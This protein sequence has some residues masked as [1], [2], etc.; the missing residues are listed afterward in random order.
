[1]TDLAGP[2]VRVLL[3]YAGAGLMTKAGIS[4]DIT[5]PDVMTLAEFAIGGLL[6]V[7]AEAWWALARKNGWGR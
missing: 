7:G 6:S 2:L 3:R 4:F 5:D 1:V